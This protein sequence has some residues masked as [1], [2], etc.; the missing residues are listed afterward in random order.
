[1]AKELGR[2]RDGK[3]RA[4]PPNWNPGANSSSSSIARTPR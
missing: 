2:R 1:M 3:K 4:E